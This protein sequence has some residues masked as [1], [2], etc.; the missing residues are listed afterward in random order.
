LDNETKDLKASVQTFK[1]LNHVFIDFYKKIHSHHLSFFS[2]NI[3][4]IRFNLTQ[5]CNIRCK[6]C[7]VDFKNKVLDLKE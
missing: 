6:Y 1:K 4:E 5:Q 2:E 3:E 7:Y